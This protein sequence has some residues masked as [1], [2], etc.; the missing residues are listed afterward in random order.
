MSQGFKALLAVVNRLSKMVYYIRTITDVNSK[1][2][3][4][5]FLD[6]MFPLHGLPDSIISDHETQFISQFMRLLTNLLG[7]QQKVSTA[8]HLQT[9]SQTEHINAI[10]KQYLQG[11]CNYQ[12]DNWSELISMMEL[13]YNNILSTVR[14]L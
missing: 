1:G 5:L 7:I 6:N 8:F 12:Q 2:I 11:Y 13:S 10:V 4:R 9:D 3:A 14:N